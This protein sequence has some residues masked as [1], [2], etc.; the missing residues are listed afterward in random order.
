[1]YLSGEKMLPV[2]SPTHRTSAIGL[3]SPVFQE[4]IRQGLHPIVSP[5]RNTAQVP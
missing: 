1:M 2:L 4:V 3:I 5:N